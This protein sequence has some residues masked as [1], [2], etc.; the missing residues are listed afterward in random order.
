MKKVRVG[1]VR[2][3]PSSEYDISLKTGG[4]VLKHL[5]KEYEGVDVLL[6]K[7]GKW[8]FGGIPKEPAEIFDEIDVVFNAM[9][10]EFGED[11]GVQQFFNSFNAPYTGSEAF[12]SALAMKKHLAYE[13]FSR[14]GIKMPKGKI[15][16]GD[17]FLGIDAEHC[18]EKV[19]RAMSP[20]WIVKPS[21]S[22]SSVGVSI[23]WSF[24]ELMAG[25][26]N[27]HQYSNF[28]LV[29]EFIKGREATCGIVDDYRGKKHY[30]LP[31]VEIVPPEGRFFDYEAKYDGST[32]E[33]CPANFDASL[34]LSL[35]HI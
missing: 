26:E 4:E 13:A 9:H 28:V 21:S 8:H 10:G 20:P 16:S 29:E 34:K 7:G 1:V 30:A 12:A 35:I 14:M 23:C 2:G 18:A 15:F 25:I 33:I 11:G 17:D 19:F 22:G 6:D 3:G 31:I 27:A 32:K 24:P 5:P